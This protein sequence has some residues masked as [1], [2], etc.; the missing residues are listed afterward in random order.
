MTIGKTSNGSAKLWWLMVKRGGPALL[1]GFYPRA[2][3]AVGLAKR[4]YR[5]GD[6]V[7]MHPILRWGYAR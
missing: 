6:F 7:H 1:F 3:F 4:A 5:A 2:G